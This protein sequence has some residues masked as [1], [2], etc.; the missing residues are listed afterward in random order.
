MMRVPNAALVGNATVYDI[1]LYVD[2]VLPAKLLYK[3][4]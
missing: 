2:N 3:Y 1:K 4:G